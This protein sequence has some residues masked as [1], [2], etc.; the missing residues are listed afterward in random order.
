MRTPVISV[1]KIKVSTR[2]LPSTRSKICIMYNGEARTSRLMAKLK[3]A[4]T[5]I[6]GRSARKAS[7]SGL[8]ER[9]VGAT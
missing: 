6:P 3:V 2:P 9:S 7:V 4:R 5:R 8:V 1:R